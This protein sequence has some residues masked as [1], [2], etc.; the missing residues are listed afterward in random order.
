V[1]FLALRHLVNLPSRQPAKEQLLKGF[2]KGV[3]MSEGTG[4]K[5]GDLVGPYKLTL[6]VKVRLG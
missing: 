6:Q 3:V 2:K 4:A 5:L 1:F